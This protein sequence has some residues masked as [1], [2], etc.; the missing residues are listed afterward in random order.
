[1]WA[2]FQRPGVHIKFLAKGCLWLPVAWVSS[3]QPHSLIKVKVEICWQ[4][5]FATLYNIIVLGTFGVI[6]WYLPLS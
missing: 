3:T 1:M 6:P 5:Q 4:D 2:V